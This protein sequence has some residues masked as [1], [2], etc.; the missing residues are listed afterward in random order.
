GYQKLFVA[1]GADLVSEILRDNWVLGEGDS[2]SAKDLGRLLTEMEQLYFRDYAVHW[3]EAI[4]QLNILP[5]ASAAQGAAQLAGLTAANSPLLQLLLEV[6]EN[7]RFAGFADATAEAGELADAAQDAGS[8]LGKAAKLATAAAE[9]AQA[10][11]LKNLPDTARKALERRFAPLHQLLDETGAAGPELIASLQALDALQLQLAS[12]AHASAPEQAAFEMAKARMGGQRDAINQL[13][14]SAARLPQPLGKWLGLLAEDSWSLVLSDAYHYLN[15]RY[16]SELYASYRG[17]LRERY[18]FSAHSASDVAIADFR[19]FFKAQGL[20]DSFFER[21]LKPF[22][23]GSAGQYQLRR[24]DGRG[25]PLSEQFL[26][27]MSRAQTIRRSF[28]AENPNEPL[29]LFKL[30]PYSLDSSLG[31]ADFRFGNQQLEYRHGPIVQTAFRW[32]A[33]ADDGRTSLVVEELGGRRVGIEKNTG[34]WSLFRLIDL[35]QVDYH[36]GRDVLMLKADLGG[37][38]ANYLLHAQRSPNPFDLALLR[39]FKL[40]ATL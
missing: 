39:G 32:P 25:L 5:A 8:K 34:P 4:A 24:V 16:R 28:F 35:M 10:S 33:E 12:L 27:Q 6:R 2:L 7:T 1:Q 9:Q 3:S 31:R 40:P 18:P 11:L 30:E 37:L 19:E 14:N 15:Q 13:R 17:S 36:S 21:Y 26:A 23:S 38:R 29:I 20:A 22:V